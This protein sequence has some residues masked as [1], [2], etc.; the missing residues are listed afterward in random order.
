[1][2]ILMVV[3]MIFVL[4]MMIMMSMITI[5]TMTMR[6]HRDVWLQTEKLSNM[7]VELF[8]FHVDDLPSANIAPF[9]RQLHPSI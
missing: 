7:G 4:I 2:M 5:T 1:M 3:M 9:F 6:R 8:Q